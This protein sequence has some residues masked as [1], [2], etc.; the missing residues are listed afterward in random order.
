MSSNKLFTDL[1]S[2]PGLRNVLLFKKGE[3]P[4]MK[5]VHQDFSLPAF[6]KSQVLGGLKRTIDQINEDSFRVELR[7]EYGRFIICSLSTDTSIAFVTNE[8]LNVPLLELA[9]KHYKNFAEQNQDEI[10]SG[11]RDE[12][13]T[14]PYSSK[15]PPAIASYSST[16]ALIS[17]DSISGVLEPIKKEEIENLKNDLIETDSNNFEI[18]CAG[19]NSYQDL[20]DNFG[21]VS[22]VAF[23]FLGKSVVANYWKQTQPEIL[24]NHFEIFVNGSVKATTDKETPG[25]DELLA[26]TIW[27]EAFIKRCEKIITDVP[28]KNQEKKTVKESEL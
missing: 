2:V 15:I 24:K 10:V 12:E 11:F 13:I 26:G 9:L 6:E 16:K 20:S 28:F 27:I 17:F 21:E 22:S 7:G 4:I 8:N 3:E 23:K 5:D 18:N 19:F 1:I 14:E 25:T